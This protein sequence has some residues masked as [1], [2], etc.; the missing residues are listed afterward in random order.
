L[1]TWHFTAGGDDIGV[2]L[3]K[4]GEIWTWGRVIGEFSPKDYLGPKGKSSDPQPRI[5]QKPWRLSNIA[6]S[7]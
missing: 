4:G 7:R 5:I 6:S 3:A 2:I 1:S